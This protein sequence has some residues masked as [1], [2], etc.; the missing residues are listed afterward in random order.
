MQATLEFRDTSDVPPW[1]F[2]KEQFYPQQPDRAS[3]ADVSG[4]LSLLRIVKL[5]GLT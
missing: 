3:Q 2:E 5:V 1:L 4:R